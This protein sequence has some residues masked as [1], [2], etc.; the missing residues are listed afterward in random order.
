MTPYMD[1]KSYCLAGFLLLWAVL[2]PGQP[3]Q[4]QTSSPQ[5][6]PSVHWEELTGADFIEGIKRSQG[7]CLLPFGILEKHGPHLPIGTDLLD[8][9][10]A[11]LHAAEQEYA[12]VFPEYYFGQIFE[13][14][15]EPG[16]VAYSRDLQLALL[17]ETTDEMAR[18]GCKK[19]LIVN[20]HGGNTSLLPYFAQS[21][22]AKAH[23]YVVYVLNQPPP[24]SGGP[25]KKTSVDQHAGESETSKMMI[26]HPDLVQQDR[27]ASESGADQHRE[28]LPDGVYTG[29]W[30]YARFPD[31]Y[32]GDGSAATREL[33]EYQ[34]N[35]WIESIAKAIV[36][37]KADEVSLKLQN[38]F[39]EKSTHPLDTK[40]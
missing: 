5:A 11:S 37:I 23:D 8:V 13:A 29:I 10:Y 19:V 35:W 33:G 22:L 40:Q 3:A 18:N 14:R 4:A 16:T 25:K 27:A 30:W 15:H 36:A 34:M 17:Q 2:S 1:R 7:T 21:Q 31:H 26:S 38:E 39:N 6:K 24:T 20:G 32:A 9:R 12:V 28:N